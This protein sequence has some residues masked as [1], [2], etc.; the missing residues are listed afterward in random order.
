M[1][2]WLDLSEKS[3]TPPR[4][5]CLSPFWKETDVVPVPKL[6]PIKDVNKHFRPISFT[7]VLSKIAEDHL[8]EKYAKP[9]VLKKIDERQFGTVLNLCTTHALIILTHNCF[10]STDG[11]GA[12][13]RVVLFDFRKVFE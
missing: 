13:T 4:E 3:S 10:V 7:A 11:K 2:F 6:R 9:A 1:T 12:A 5:S 8:V